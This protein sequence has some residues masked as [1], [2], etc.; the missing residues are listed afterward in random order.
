MKARKVFSRIGWSYVVFLLVSGVF[1]VMLVI[2]GALAAVLSGTEEELLSDGSMLMILSQLSMYLL[3][4]PV[5][6]LMMGRVPSWHKTDGPEL[7]A[8]Q[9]ALLAVGCCGLTYI[10]SIFGQ[11]LVQIFD[12][13]RGAETIN[14]V[15]D[16]LE[17]MNP[18]SVLL[19][20]VIAAPIME[21]LMFRKFLVDRLIPYGQKLAVVV[22][23]IS[24]GLFHGNWNQ[25]F[26]AFLLGM[27]FAFIY[28]YTGK[29]RYSILLHMAVN[30]AGGF[31]PVFLEQTVSPQ[32]LE[33]ETAQVL[34][35]V[36]MGV[37]IAAAAAAAAV[38]L[39]KLTWNRPWAQQPEDGFVR[40]LFKAPGVWFFLLITAGQ[41]A[42]Y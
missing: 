7:T 34:L 4:F 26:Y 23:G 19:T 2:A 31:M 24:F 36:W 3:G 13:V 12:Q 14:P 41:F 15:T 21:E 16:T 38:Y 18:W 11:F 27:V 35:L 32:L 37:S 20:M 28:S 39:P 9:L 17:Q 40:E 33:T 5:F 29:L 1:Q 10:G 30:T 22:S 6:V 42:V 25:F 8:G